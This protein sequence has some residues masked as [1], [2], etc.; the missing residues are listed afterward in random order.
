MALTKQIKAAWIAEM[1]DPNT[2][3]CFGV[4]YVDTLHR[5]KIMSC[6]MADHP[7]EITCMC[8]LGC[9]IKQ[10][11][12]HDHKGTAYSWSAIFTKAFGV[13]DNN[14]FEDD[15]AYAKSIGGVDYVGEIMKMNDIEHKSLNEIADWV[16][17]NVPTID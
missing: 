13:F 16:E 12:L 8:A 9:L 10:S 11:L 2:Q 6:P 17:A 4:Y 3:Q 5:E 14:P 15:C 7:K 1:R